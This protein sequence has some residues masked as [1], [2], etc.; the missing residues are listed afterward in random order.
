MA[1]HSSVIARR[2]PCIE[3]PG[4]LQSMESESGKTELLSTQTHPLKNVCTSSWIVLWW[5]YI[6]LALQSKIQ[7]NF[8]YHVINHFKMYNFNIIQCIHSIVQLPPHSGFKF[9]RRKPSTHYKITPHYLFSPFS[10]NHWLTFC[11]YGFVYSDSVQ[12]SSVTQSCPTLC[13]PMDCSTP[14][15][16]VQHQLLEF[17]QIHVY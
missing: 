4:R 1:T 3:E 8:I 7:V 10:G 16:P 2:I 5:V 14:G 17:T 13:S 11:L 15:L 9:S 12:F 6:H